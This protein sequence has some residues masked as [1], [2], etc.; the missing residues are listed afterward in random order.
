MTSP[1]FSLSYDRVFILFVFCRDPKP[2]IE[3]EETL[4]TSKRR[5]S[6]WSVPSAE[7]WSWDT[8]FAENASKLEESV[9][10]ATINVENSLQSASIDDVW[11]KLFLLFLNLYNLLLEHVCP[12]L[13]FHFLFMMMIILQATRVF[14]NNTNQKRIHYSIYFHNRIVRSSLQVRNVLWFDFSN[15]FQRTQF[16]SPN[17]QKSTESAK[18]TDVNLLRGDKHQFFLIF[19]ITESMDLVIFST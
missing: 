11:N 10:L 12:F 2:S 14:K 7:K 4:I 19:I 1:C 15:G 8:T 13:L 5:Q 6:L 3:R 18:N 9:V 17:T 16:T